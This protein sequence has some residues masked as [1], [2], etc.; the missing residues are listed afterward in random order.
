MCVLSASKLFLPLSN[1]TC[2][3]NLPQGFTSP[4]DHPKD[5][6]NNGSLRPYSEEGS[7]NKEMFSKTDHRSLARIVL[8][9]V[10]L[11]GKARTKLLTDRLGELVTKEG[12]GRLR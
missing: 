11:M 8:M 2:H 6:Q 12:Q 5:T 3:I 7:G 10:R 1:R 9:A 4:R